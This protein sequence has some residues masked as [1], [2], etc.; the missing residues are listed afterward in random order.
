M[1]NMYEYALTL[2]KQ[3]VAVNTCNPPGQEAALAIFLAK[4]LK[5]FGR[6]STVEWIS[7]GRAN[8]V[9]RIQGKYAGPTLALTGHLDTVPAG[10][11]W[12]SD[13]FCQTDKGDG[14][15]Y[16][17]GVCDM[18]GGI[19]A[20]I[21][22]VRRLVQQKAELHGDILLCYVAD[23]EATSLGL[24]HF[25]DAGG[26]ADYAVIGEPT[27]MD[28]NI[29]HKG[30]SR[31]LLTIHGKGGHAARPA[32]TLN[33]ISK[34]RYLLEAIANIQAKLNRTS[35]PLLGSATISVTMVHAGDKGNVIPSQCNC[36]IDRR[37][38]PGECVVQAEAELAEEL[39][40]IGGQ[41]PEFSFDL[42][43]YL[44]TAAGEVS[45]KSPLVKAALD[46]IGEVRGDRREA[47]A[48]SGCCEQTLW[49]KAGTQ[50][51][52]LGPGSLAQ[53]HMPDEYLEKEQLFLAVD[54][55][56]KLIK[57]LLH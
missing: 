14:K 34:I 28:V 2:L 38:L 50:A 21:A 39:E 15:V 51:I 13:P 49:Q 56:E 6:D 23:E 7:T 45:E 25:F 48:F 52:V 22:A 24:R 53:A 17:R 18:K 44:N 26:K 35:H 43:T 8:V 41:D 57:K 30:V 11:A 55:Y 20:Q 27:Q 12:N 4:E 9:S 5:Q 36:K 32:E 19:A 37:L 29:C 10:H 3:M 42:H 33:P 31:M 47:Y 46:A 40:R 1:D 54:C 16:G